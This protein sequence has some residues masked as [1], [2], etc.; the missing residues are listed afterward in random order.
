MAAASREVA[1]QARRQH[2]L[3]TR[4]QASA[5]GVSRSGWYRMIDRG[6]LELLHPAV[7]RIGG[8]PATDRQA[9]L[10]GVLACGPDALASHTAAAVVWGVEL[11][12][13]RVEV[14]LARRSGG[15]AVAGVAIHRP[16]DLVDLAPVRRDHIPVTNPLR[17]L[18]DLGASRPVADVERALD[19]LVVR[20]T[21]TMPAVRAALA[22]HARP[23]RSGVV[24]LRTVV[25][26]WALGDERPDSEPEAEVAR[27]LAGAGVGEPV[28]HHRVGRYEVDL[29]WP[30][31]RVALEVDGWEVHGRRDAFEADRLRDL[32]LQALG[33]SVLHVSGRSVRR[34]SPAVLAWVSEVVQRRAVA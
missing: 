5:A 20:G 26:R 22:R 7:A 14:T 27:W 13:W 32:H 16:A 6:Q 1:A 4:E 9:V 12:R 25:D 31:L 3:I 19:Q 15:R 17:L 18:V 29:A 30:D 11:D 28:P 24:A 2:G 33:W 21:V 23:G 8:A 10:A 34:R